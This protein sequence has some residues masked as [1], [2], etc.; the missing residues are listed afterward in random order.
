MN[1]LIS[2]GGIAGLT[3][4]YWLRE[5]GFQPIVIDKATEFRRIGYPLGTYGA[6]VQILEKMGLLDTL[7][8]KSIPMT[9][10]AFV[11]GNGQII[12]KLDMGK[13]FTV[14][15]RNLAL[16]RAD[17]HLTIYD[18]VKD[19][20]EIRFGRSIESI[21]Q[22][23]DRVIAT[24]DSGKTESFN[25]L[26][27]AD[28]V[29][30]RTRRQ[31]FGSGFEKFFN[32]AYMAF[33]SQHIPSNLGDCNYNITLPRRFAGIGKY[34]SLGV[35]A[36]LLYQSLPNCKIPPSERVAHLLK[37]FSDTEWLIPEVI[38]SVE[39]PN[40]IFYDDML[41]IVMP[42]WSKGRVC[43]LGDAA[44]TLTLMSG[45]GAGM[46]ILG[47]YL[48]AKEL[49]QQSYETAFAAYENQLRR[50]VDELQKD[51]FKMTQMM[52]PD[53]QWAIALT[54]LY[55]KYIPESWLL[56]RFTKSPALIEAL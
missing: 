5:Y 14:G 47:A 42:Q 51:A 44:Y 22:Q 23:S 15:E 12:R 28:G 40:T 25:L 54:N 52:L 11:D 17:L 32:V 48:L 18:A 43:L 55:I 31:V 10:S 27:G 2:G 39:D 19:Q 16:S 45:R 53:H 30:S 7:A 6:S 46:A 37:E 35:G 38:R 9:E 29:H 4:A 1:I 3:L 33:F 36:F 41:Q 24:F 21:E 34:G 26:I 49:A 20:V 13:F 8:A 50:G 56:K